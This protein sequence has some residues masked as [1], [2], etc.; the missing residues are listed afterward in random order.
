MVGAHDRFSMDM[1]EAIL[2]TALGFA[3]TLVVMMAAWNVAQK[4]VSQLNDKVVA[5]VAN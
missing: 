3:P 1:T 2:W 4:K 5:G